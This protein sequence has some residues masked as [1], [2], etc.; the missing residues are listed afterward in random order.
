MSVPYTPATRIPR[1]CA[2]LGL[3]VLLW[4]LVQAG[5]ALAGGAQRGGEVLLEGRWQP[6]A[7]DDGSWHDFDPARLSRIAR[8]SGGS[9]LQLR[10]RHGDWPRE[11]EWVVSIRA[12]GFGPYRWQADTGDW[13]TASLLQLP[14]QGIVGHNRVGIPLPVMGEGEPLELQLDP[15][16]YMN[17]V[18]TFALLSRA[19]YERDNSRF[20]V[21]STAVLAVLMTMVVLSCIF[22]QRFA[23]PTFIF[24]AGYLLAYSLVMGMQTGYVAS[25]LGWSWI[26]QAPTTW[27]RVATCGAVVLAVFFLREFVNLRRFA[28]RWD[29]TMRVFCWLMLVVSAIGLLPIAPLQAAMRMLVNPLLLIGG[30]LTLLAG[31]AGWRGGSRYGGYF[32]AGWTPL[33]LITAMSSGQY[34]GWLPGWLWMDEAMLVAAAFESFVLSAGLADR[35][36]L[37]RREHEAMRTEAGTDPLTET[38]NRR[39]LQQQLDRHV[40]QA[41]RTTG[42]LAL[43]FVDLDG[44]KRL[45]DSRGH[46]LGDQALRRVAT[47]LRAVLGPHDVLGRYGGDEFIMLIAGVD[48]AT[49]VQRARQACVHIADSGRPPAF[50]EHPLTAS[51]GVAVL[52]PGESADSLLSRADAAMYEV[53]HAGGN[54]VR[55]SDPAPR[56]VSDQP[57]MASA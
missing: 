32:V 47:G 12:P 56:P 46:A 30:P 26:T 34:M 43:F 20:L 41:H 5:V 55:C 17:G 21:I 53:K 10:P 25:V 44:F 36:H 42:M 11:G 50:G 7:A 6:V 15:A 24:Y 54:G 2:S 8:P 57:G 31:W 18:V 3:A 40:Q 37:R 33:L 22:A 27:G 9:T 49:A 4:L 35:V 51:I 48:V 28:P 39:T 14:R 1:A 19:A 52:Q 45:N 16:P 38:L 29:V 13:H 23:D